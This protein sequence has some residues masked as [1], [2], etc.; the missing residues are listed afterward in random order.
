MNRFAFT[1]F[2]CIMLMMC[3]AV[4]ANPLLSTAQGIGANG[5]ILQAQAWFGYDG[6]H[7]RVV[8][9][10][11]APNLSG[12]TSN[13]VSSLFW[14]VEIGDVFL[15]PVSATASTLVDSNNN[16]VGNSVNVLPN[17][18]W[19]FSPGALFM[20]T[21]YGVGGAGL[22]FFPPSSPGQPD[23]ADYLIT[24]ASGV[25]PGSDGIDAHPPYINN[26][27][28]YI[29]AVTGGN[30]ALF[31][32]ATDIRNIFFGYGTSLEYYSEG[33]IP[34]PSTFVMAGIALGLLFLGSSKAL[35]NK[36]E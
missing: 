32:P 2:L 26:Q 21:S 11:T 20:G 7:L 36:K 1:F 16:V 35:F 34:E 27:L 17:W 29:F 22:G 3:S 33:T 18:S 19:A 5:E 10:N 30:A 13:L 6:T 4:Q 15:T 31:N 12:F 25:V 8:L 28:I 14:S 23:G 24:P 9:T